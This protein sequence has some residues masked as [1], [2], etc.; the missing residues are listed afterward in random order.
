MKY[1]LTF[2]LVL[3]VLISSA[4]S[5][6]THCD[7]YQQMTIPYPGI[8]QF[9]GIYAEDGLHLFTSFGGLFHYYPQTTYWMVEQID[10]I[11]PESGKIN[12]I[13][14]GDGDFAAAVIDSTGK[15]IVYKGQ[16]G[17]WEK[18]SVPAYWNFPGNVALLPC[19]NGSF[20]VI[21]QEMSTGGLH[22]IIGIKRS[23]DG[24]WDTLPVYLGATDHAIENMSACSP[25]DDDICLFYGSG[26]PEYDLM[27]IRYHD[28]HIEQS[29]VWML[30]EQGSN[31]DCAVDSSGNIHLSAWDGWNATLLYGFFNGIDWTFQNPDPRWGTG[32]NTSI[33]TDNHDFPAIMYSDYQTNDLYVSFWDGN[34]WQSQPVG[35]YGIIY[36]D[37]QFSPCNQILFNDNNEIRALL[38][39][40][41]GISLIKPDLL[42]TEPIWVFPEIQINR[43]LLYPNSSEPEEPAF[44]FD[45]E[46]QAYIME[47][48][49]KS[50]N[51]VPVKPFFETPS[52]ILATNFC[53][54]GFLH[55][56]V[57]LPGGIKNWIVDQNSIIEENDIPD[58]PCPGP[59][60]IDQLGFVHQ[61]YYDD[62][63]GRYRTNGS[64]TWIE[65][66][67]AEQPEPTFLM[68]RYFVKELSIAEI[69]RPV[70]F[71]VSGGILGASVSTFY[72]LNGT[73][74]HNALPVEIN[75][76]EVIFDDATLSNNRPAVLL[77]F[78]SHSCYYKCIIFEK[79]QY[80]TITL[81]ISTKYPETGLKMA[82]NDS[83]NPR[84]IDNTGT[85]Y[86]YN[87]YELSSLE[88]GIPFQNIID[89]VSAGVD[90]YYVFS[91]ENDQG[92]KVLSIT[93]D[94]TILNLSMPNTELTAGDLFELNYTITN[95]ENLQGDYNLIVLLELPG[96][97]YY[98]WPDWRDLSAN[99]PA[100]FPVHVD[101]NQTIH[102][103]IISFR[104]PD[105]A[106]SSETLR[107][108]GALMYASS[109]WT[110]PSNVN[111]LYY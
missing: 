19:N 49:D 25:D 106:G 22:H 9:A 54:D 32:Y 80:E 24:E 3:I 48:I 101:M 17:H 102:G 75:V 26:Y 99:D 69:N 8:D 37:D 111:W 11:C 110:E 15:I 34:A 100:F 77:C 98:S 2:S 31:L 42:S 40:D 47:K 74:Q 103:N 27:M 72:K 83:G 23:S 63:Y 67:V 14:S 20:W 96:N 109:Y 36:N 21:A 97:I 52:T 92:I 58:N 38:R 35:D 85:F 93:G 61:A 82:C 84:F 76:S 71:C 50:W 86:I 73:W 10:D 88:L 4:H 53:D 45:C 1:Y 12:L 55:A 108:I 7:Y 87:G 66:I 5:Y 90:D 57:E 94:A 30:G 68:G 44:Y 18:I 41:G 46:N 16:T 29:P 95:K 104:W 81:P 6:D 65:E 89:L 39:T 51:Y 13:R 107:F 56:V 43:V 33:I 105:C 28:G 59:Y 91:I 60:V 78:D 79:T 64:G 70:I 62:E